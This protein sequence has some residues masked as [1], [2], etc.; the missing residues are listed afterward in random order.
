MLLRSRSYSSDDGGP[1]H[2][3]TTVIAVDKD[4][5]SN[6]AVKWAVDHLL[7]NMPLLVLVHVRMITSPNSMYL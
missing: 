5:N 1:V 3:V 6:Q 7:S 4:K 2:E